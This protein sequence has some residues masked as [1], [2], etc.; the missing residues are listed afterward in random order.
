MNGRSLEEIGKECYL[1]TKLSEIPGQGAPDIPGVVLIG[2]RGSKRRS[3]AK[4]LKEI[5]DIVHGKHTMA[6][7]GLL[8]LRHVTD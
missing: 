3:V 1:V 2:M 8:T 7:I 6:C 4:R 5:F